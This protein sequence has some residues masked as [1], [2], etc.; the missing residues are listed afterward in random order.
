MTQCDPAFEG[1]RVYIP[2]RLP[3]VNHL[4]TQFP[5][6]EQRGTSRPAAPQTPPAALGQHL[7]RN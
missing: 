4:F 7:R 3:P 6:K 1:W 5:V 2:L